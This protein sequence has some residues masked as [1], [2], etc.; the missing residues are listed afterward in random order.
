MF[1]QRVRKTSTSG[2]EYVLLPLTDI[3][4]T[5][6]QYTLKME[7]PGITKDKLEVLLENNELEI[8]GGAEKHDSEGKELQYSE[9]SQY[10]YYRKYNVG[11]DIDRNGINATFENGVL[12][13]V[14][15]KHEAVKPKRIPINVR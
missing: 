2:D 6:D 8:R 5:E 7:M 1:D 14:L 13:L 10:D 12:T 4:E 9:F 11:D 3:Y 15:K